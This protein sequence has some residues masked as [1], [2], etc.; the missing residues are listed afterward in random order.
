MR[1]IVLATVLLSACG[2]ALPLERATTVVQSLA[3]ARESAPGVSVG[4][5]VDAQV[6]TSLDSRSCNK[7]DF[8]DPS[9][10]GGIDNQMARLMPLIDLAGQGAVDA[11]VQASISAGRLMMFVSVESEPGSDQVTVVFERGDDQPLVGGDGKLLSGQTLALHAEP[12][13]GRITGTRQ[14]DGSLMVGPFA[15]RFPIV[16]FNLFFELDFSEAWVHLTPTEDGGHQ[17]VLGGWTPV[18]EILAITRTA[19]SDVDK[20]E[21]LFSNGIREAADLHKDPATGLCTAMSLAATFRTVT[22]FQY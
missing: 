16:V 6:S 4:F 9:G 10:V 22:A 19:D 14:A 12:D 13:L 2:E 7:E 18:E 5:D 21:D 1:E 8:V 3:L 15:L 11:L 17:A 20:Y